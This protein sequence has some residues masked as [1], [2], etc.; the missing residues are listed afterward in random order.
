M[1]N[2]TRDYAACLKN[3]GNFHVASILKEIPR[4]VSYVRSC[5]Q[6]FKDLSV[7]YKNG[8]L[9]YFRYFTLGNRAFSIVTEYKHFIMK[10]NCFRLQMKPETFIS[11]IT[12]Y[13]NITLSILRFH[14]NLRYCILLFIKKKSVLIHEFCKLRLVR[15]EN[16]RNMQR[17]QVSIPTNT[18]TLS[19][20]LT[21]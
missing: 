7:F 13:H 6:V 2:K 15:A 18:K 5:R 14:S 9:K 21:E 16:R 8:E 11:K 4:N 1:K 20:R 10:P 19:L 17:S 12:K 3:S